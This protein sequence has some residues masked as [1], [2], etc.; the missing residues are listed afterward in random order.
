M[1]NHAN[2][3]IT[4]LLDNNVREIIR[5]E[6]HIKES[7]KSINKYKEYLQESENILN[8]QRK[9]LLDLKQSNDEIIEIMK[10]MKQV[11]K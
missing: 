6:E 8:R 1:S 7:E 4:E 5:K 2:K 11:K 9:E 10:L 3:L